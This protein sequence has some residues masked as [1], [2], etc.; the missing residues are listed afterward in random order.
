M[1]MKSDADFPDEMICLL[2]TTQ[3]PITRR[4]DDGARDGINT[5]NHAFITYSK[6]MDVEQDSVNYDNAGKKTSLKHSTAN[7]NSTLLR[8]RCCQDSEHGKRISTRARPQRLEELVLVFAFAG[9]EKE[10]NERKKER[11]RDIK[12]KKGG[13]MQELKIKTRKKRE[14]KKGKKNGEWGRKKREE[15]HAFLR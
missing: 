11:K 2:N 9:R 3:R 13:L 10:N 1:T 12:R 6:Q 14:R 15:N 5:H 8:C 7:K 4:R